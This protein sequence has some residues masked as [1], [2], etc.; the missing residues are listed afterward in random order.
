MPD[1][2]DDLQLAF[3]YH[4]A[5][6]L[7]SV[8]EAVET[9]ELA[10]L[11]ETFSRERLVAAGLVD[12]AGHVTP[13]FHECRDRALVELPGAL[14]EDAK[15]RLIGVVADASAAD[16]VLSP[17]EADALSAVAR[18]L[19]IDDRRWLDHVEAM[20]ATGRLRRDATGIG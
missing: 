10:F 14:D 1:D 3:A 16:G 5:V 2:L 15:L 17:E 13:K 12:P 4:L 9:P 18:I 11:G 20:I 7:V 8:D 19:Q 6:E